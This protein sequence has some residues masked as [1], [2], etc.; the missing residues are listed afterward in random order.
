MRN[1]VYNKSDQTGFASKHQLLGKNQLLT[2]FD[3]VVINTENCLYQQYKFVNGSTLVYRFIEVKY[4]PSDYIK[5]QIQK[6]EPLNSQTQAFAY[7]TYEVNVSRQIQNLPMV[8]FNYVVQTS[9]E[10]PFYVFKVEGIGQEISFRYIA[11]IK[12]DE[13]YIAYFK[14]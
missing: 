4:K 14:F 1:R 9:G 8:E 3:S 7:L 11:E 2:D 5:N 12:N 10:Y 13:D 6:I